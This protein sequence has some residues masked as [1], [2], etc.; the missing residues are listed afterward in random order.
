MNSVLTRLNTLE[1][2]SIVQQ[3]VRDRDDNTS[4]KPNQTSSWWPF[5]NFSGRTVMFL[6][7]WPIIVHWVIR[8]LSG[9]RRRPT[10]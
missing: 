2:L 8:F 4:R 1:T 9:R 3:Q 10:R 5:P 6:L 7:V